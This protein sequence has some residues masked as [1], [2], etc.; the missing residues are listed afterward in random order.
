MTGTMCVAI[1]ADYRDSPDDWYQVGG[2]TA[3]HACIWGMDGDKSYGKW[4]EGKK[5]DSFWEW[6]YRWA[7]DI[8]DLPIFGWDMWKSWCVLDGTMEIARKCIQI[9]VSKDCFIAENPP[10]IITCRRSKCRISFMDLDNL[11]ISKEDYDVRDHRAMLPASKMAVQEYRKMCNEFDMGRACE[12]SASQAWNIFSARYQQPRRSPPEA[13]PLESAAYF[14]GRAECRRLGIIEEKLYQLDISAMY[15]SL[16]R[17]GAFPMELVGIEEKPPKEGDGLMIA[18]VTLKTPLALYP[19]RGTSLILNGLGALDQPEAGIYGERIIYPV[20]T[21]RTALC[22]PELAVAMGNNHV[23]EWHSV[24]HYDGHAFMSQWADWALATRQAVKNHKELH[25]LTTCFKRIM[26][27]LPGKWNQ[28]NVIWKNY[29]CMNGDPGEWHKEY[30]RHPEDGR[31]TM[32]RTIAGK[33]QYRD[34]VELADHARPAV[35]AYWTSYGRAL[36]AM[37]MGIVETDDLFYYHT[38]SLIVNDNGLEALG[39][40]VGISSTNEPGRLR[41]VGKSEWTNFLGISRYFFDGQWVYAGI[42]PGDLEEGDASEQLWRG[43]G[44]GVASQS[45][46]VPKWDTYRH[47]TVTE[48]GIVRPFVIGKT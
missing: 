5:A 45:Q 9:D 2:L 6:L 20:G 13:R 44:F 16:A 26:N 21:F 38:D 17:L 24:Q 23:L 7:D 42:M 34:E 43:K 33:C 46:N 35:A 39:N 12:T 37:L 1:E 4:N 31:M 28:R 19:C 47:G 40:S 3:W 36:L 22:G 15:T 27:S 48:D 10:T 32:F 41:L 30:G 8:K 18:D 29:P 25:R 14:G 11:G